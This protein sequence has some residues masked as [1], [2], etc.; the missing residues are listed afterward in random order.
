MNKEKIWLLNEELLESCQYYGLAYTKYIDVHV[1]KI[2]SLKHKYFRSYWHK[3][4]IIS[5]WDM[6][7][8]VQ[9]T[10]IKNT[11]ISELLT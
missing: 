11:N 7:A 9:K 8:Q 5:P 2:W 10:W 4:Q 6:K 3:Y 1:C